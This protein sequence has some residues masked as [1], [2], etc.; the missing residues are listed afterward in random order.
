MF[1]AQL[2]ESGTI[3]KLIESIREL[4]HEVNIEA[5]PAG[6]ALQAMDSSHVA[7]ISMNLRSDGFHVFRCDKPVTLGRLFYIGI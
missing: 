5:T 4:V 3:K 6:I 2:E 7:L 1:E